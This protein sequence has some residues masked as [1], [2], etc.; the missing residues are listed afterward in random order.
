MKPL[1]ALCCLAL[2]LSCKGDPKQEETAEEVAVTTYYLIRHAEKDR[3]NPEEKDPALTEEGHQR[4]QRWARHFKDI[5]LDA[6]YSTDYARTTSTA[7]PTAIDHD[8]EV[9]LYD[10]NA[11]YDDA[12]AKATQGKTVLIVGHSNTTPAFA[13]AIM[14]KQTFK[15]MSDGDNASLFK[16]VIQG[17]QKE[18]SRTFVN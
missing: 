12:F 1:F 8:L 3:S 4:A 18:A 17:K 10:P 9:Q 6:V 13:N 15:A 11:L 5:T 7:V 2:L 14:G 16:V